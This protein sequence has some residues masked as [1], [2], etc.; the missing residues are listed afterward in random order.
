[1]NRAHRINQEIEQTLGYLDGNEAIGVSAGF[2]ET[3]TERFGSIGRPGAGVYHRGWVRAT[4]FA[5][6]I[7]L[8][9]AVSL[10]WFA[11]RGHSESLAASEVQVVADEYSMEQGE[12]MSF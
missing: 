1:M 6:M 10:T 2:T 8:N 11:P 7:V 3:L 9:I 12:Y 4:G 5:L